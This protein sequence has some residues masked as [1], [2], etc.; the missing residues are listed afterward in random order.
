M[1][2]WSSQH[3]STLADSLI[4]VGLVASAIEEN[5]GYI[6]I[7]YS[8]ANIASAEAEIAAAEDEAL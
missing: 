1:T 6:A 7:E 2:V 5:S 3:S 8:F 4:S